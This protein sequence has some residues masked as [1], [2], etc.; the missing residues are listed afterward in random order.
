MKPLVVRKVPTT[1]LQLRAL[2]EEVETYV[3][4]LISHGAAPEEIL[5]RCELVDGLRAQARTIV[6]MYYGVHFGARTRE[7]GSRG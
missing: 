5:Q 3:D 4:D 6:L 1:A 7:P 2:A